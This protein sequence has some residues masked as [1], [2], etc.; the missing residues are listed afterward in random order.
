[1]M[2]KYT[3]LCSCQ[4]FKCICMHTVGKSLAAAPSTEGGGGCGQ[5][6]VTAAMATDDQTPL[7]LP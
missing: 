6:R 4:T 5:E 3:V 7:R 2:K 1:M